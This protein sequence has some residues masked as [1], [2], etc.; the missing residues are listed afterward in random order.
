M[1]EELRPDPDNLLKEI[2]KENRGKL[3]VFLGAAAGV[4]KTYTMLVTA[5]E[6]IKEGRNILIGWIVTHG[7]KE[8]D[9][10]LPGIPRVEPVKI[11]YKGKDFYEMDIDTILKKKP[12]IVLID[13]LAHTNVPGSRNTKRYQDVEEL[14]GDGINV[15]TTL[16]IQH[17]ESLNDVISKITGITVTETIPDK[18]LEEAEI[19]LVDIDADALIQ[20]LKDGKVY[21]PVQAEEAILKFFR[22]GNINALREISLRY[23]ADSIDNHLENYMQ[24]HGIKGPWPAGEKVMVCVSKNNLATNLIRMGKRMATSLNAELLVVNVDT[25]WERDLTVSEQ[26]MH[27]NNLK[28]AESLGAE[29]ITLTGTNVADEIINLARKRNVTQLIIG[30]PLKP[31]AIEWFQESV[32]DKIIRN[33]EGIRIHVIPSHLKKFKRKRIIEKKFVNYLLPYLIG[34]GL[35]L[36]L[37]LICKNFE[38][39]IGI[40]NITLLFAIPAVIVA[41]FWGYLASIIISIASFLTFDFYFTPPRNQ[42]AISDFRFIPSFFIYLILAVL[43]CYLSKKNRIQMRFVEKREEQL[44]ILYS[45]S[46]KISSKMNLNEVIENVKEKIENLINCKVIFLI[47]SNDGSLKVHEQNLDPELNIK[48]SVEKEKAVAD[49]VSLNGSIAGKGTDFL[50]NSEMIYFPLKTQGEIVGVIGIFLNAEKSLLTIEEKKLI[51]AI[52]GLLGAVVYRINI[53]SKLNETKILEES[54][55]L[56]NALFNSLSHDL[57]TPLTSIIGSSSSLESDETVLSSQDKK[58]LIKNIN[59]SSLRMLRIVNN[60]L[61]MARIESEHTILN[62]EWCDIEDIIGVA[63]K[64]VENIGERKLDIQTSDHIPLIW[65]DFSLIGQVFINLLDNSVKYS[66]PESKIT[67]RIFIN[68]DKLITSITDEGIGVTQEE[69]SKIFNKFHR[70]KLLE[71]IHGTGLG[72]SICKSIIELHKGKIWAES[73]KIS[74]LTITFSLPIYS[75]PKIEEQINTSLQKAE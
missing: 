12:E 7:R 39:F 17:L 13:E 47:R 20:R 60:L 35:I 4:G 62:Y 30:K 33:S 6:R 10:L 67:I 66:R 64:E 5:K 14:L 56:Y 59:Q 16:N 18:I 21:I 43:I 40:F 1:S 58:D 27:L 3:I 45:L 52:C 71:N 2:S 57:R 44:S 19:H 28:L 53:I 69:I 65:A 63:I 29:V 70:V 32:V 50:N 55:K 34:F 51:E 25:P 68:T 72:L 24:T 23:T 11:N 61:D 37:A 54:Q 36:V 22:P 46:R 9:E 42:F 26:N 74:G 73:K 41:F 15:Y 48:I 75:Q 8:T 31:R 49:W 38:T